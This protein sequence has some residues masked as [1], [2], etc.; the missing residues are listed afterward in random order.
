MD[1]REVTASER[2]EWELTATVRIELYL[3]ICVNM[4][5]T[6]QNSDFICEPVI[7]DGQIR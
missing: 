5:S 2:I 6:V 3:T 4:T 1:R 7:F